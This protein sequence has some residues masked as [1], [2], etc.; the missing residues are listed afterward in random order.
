MLEILLFQRSSVD[1]YGIYG[2]KVRTFFEKSNHQYRE[3]EDVFRENENFIQE[4]EDT[5]FENMMSLQW[6][7]PVL[8]NVTRV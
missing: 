8:K 1:N 2:R 4:S 3:S 6:L 7:M 5:A